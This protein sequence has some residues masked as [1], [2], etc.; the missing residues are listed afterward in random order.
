MGWKD[1]EG[2]NFL[3]RGFFF[4]T[5]RHVIIDHLSALSLSWILESHYI[6]F[7]KWFRLIIACEVLLYW[8]VDSVTELSYTYTWAS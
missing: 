5:V 6:S 4:L 1:K 3:D 8:S 7:G 2:T